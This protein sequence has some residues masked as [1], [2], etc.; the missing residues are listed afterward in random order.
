MTISDAFTN[1]VFFAFQ[2]DLA[3][4]MMTLP[5]AMRGH[6]YRLDKVLYYEFLRA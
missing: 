4:H 3:S 2:V 6:Y 5:K 1:K